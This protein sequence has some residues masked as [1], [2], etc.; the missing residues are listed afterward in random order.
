MKHETFGERQRRRTSD[1]VDK[2]VLVLIGV[3]LIAVALSTA[4]QLVIE[5]SISG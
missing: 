3:V 4:A 1:M 5:S 2:L